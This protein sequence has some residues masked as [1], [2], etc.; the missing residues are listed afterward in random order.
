[1]RRV[2]VRLCTVATADRT[3]TREPH[4]QSSSHNDG[5][6]NGSYWL[7]VCSSRA[8]VCTATGAQP[9]AATRDE[10]FGVT[11]AERAGSNNGTHS[12]FSHSFR[13]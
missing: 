7:S 13:R 9:V 11:P 5:E 12:V 4:I 10:D 6:R 3:S 1:M 8:L 2:A